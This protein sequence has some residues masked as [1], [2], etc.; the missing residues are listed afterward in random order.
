MENT[1][2]IGYLPRLIEIT[3]LALMAVGTVFVFSASASV[4]TEYNLRYFSNFANLKQFLF[5]PLA[6]GLM[7]AVASNNY[8][9]FSF[10]YAAVFKSITVYLLFLSIALLVLVLCIGVVTNGARRWLLLTIGPVSISFQPSELAKWAMIFFLVAFLDKYPDRISIY[11]TG[12]VPIC[13]LAGVIIGLIIT[14][15]FGTAALISLLTFLMLVV[16][17]VHWW[18]L[19]TTLPFISAAFFFAIVLSPNRLKRLIDFVNPDVTPYQV[20]QSLIAIGSGGICGKGL[21]MG[22]S[23]YGYLPQ[24][25]TDF[26]FSIIAEELGFVGAAVVIALFVVLILLGIIVMVRCNNSFGRLLAGAIVMTIGIQ[27]AINIGVATN[28]LPTT[29]IPLPFV[30]TGGT[31]LLLSAAAVGVLVNIAKQTAETEM[32]DSAPSF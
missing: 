22:T 5:F 29:G 20:K 15:D 1:A 13:L 23:K 24:D 28:T 4:S 3:V 19:L 7:F 2:K 32:E 8:R 6:V 17:R 18:H 27:A 31:S 12:F 11:W 26:I 30:S 14:Q 10:T 21:G 16:G 25:T 9:K